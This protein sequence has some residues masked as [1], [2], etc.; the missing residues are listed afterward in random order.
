MSG[1][2]ECK[3][4]FGGSKFEL[5][6]FSDAD[7]AGDILSRKSTTGYVLFAMGGHIAWQSKLQVVIAT[8]SLESEYMAMYAGIQELLWVRGL[9]REIGLFDSLIDGPTPFLVDN[10]SAIDL[11]NNPVYHKRSKHIDIKYH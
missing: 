11:A 4:V 2:R 1:D 10:M 8:S 3:L 6:G 9:I 7:W 5:H